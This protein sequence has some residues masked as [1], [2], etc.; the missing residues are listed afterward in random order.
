MLTIYLIVGLPGSGKSTYMFQNFQ[1]HIIFDD[2]YKYDKKV[3]EESIFFNQ[4]ITAIKTHQKNIAISD[5][6]FCNTTHFNTFQKR[7]KKYINQI[8]T[9]EKIY[10]ENKLDL[11]KQNILTRNRESKYKELILCDKYSKNYNIPINSN[12]IP[13]YQFR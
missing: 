2:W 4:L 7:L 3:F 8:Y 9:I 1:N 6:K 12:I 11:C 13:V 5:I 10:F